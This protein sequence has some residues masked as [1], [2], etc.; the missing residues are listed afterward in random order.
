MFF[1]SGDRR[2]YAVVFRRAAPGS[3]RSPSEGREKLLIDEEC[4]V[5]ESTVAKRT[6][7]GSS[8]LQGALRSESEGY[9]G[10]A[11]GPTVANT[12]AATSSSRPVWVDS[13]FTSSLSFS[14]G[15]RLDEIEISAEPRGLGQ[16]VV[17]LRR[18]QHGDDH[19]VEFAAASGSISARRGPSRRAASGLSST[20]KGIG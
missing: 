5:F 13:R 9:P 4:P 14:G 7:S 18:G 10:P 2:S 16:V 11:A 8:N 20:R 19:P 1:R 17:L 15:G 3:L 6:I 12:L